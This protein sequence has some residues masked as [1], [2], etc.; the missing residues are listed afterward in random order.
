MFTVAGVTG[1]VGAVVAEQLLAKGQ[2]VRVLVRTEAKGEPWARKGAEVSLGSLDDDASVTRALQGATG[3]FVLLP[4]D[5]RAS[6]L[7]ASQRGTSDAIA[8]AVKASGVRHVVLLSSIGADLETGT[9]PIKGLHY[10]EG[11]LRA[12]GTKLTALRAGSFQENVA[13]SLGPAKEGIYPNFS[14]SADYPMPMIATRDIATVAVTSLLTPPSASEVVDISGPSYSIR[15]VSEKLGAALGKR[16]QVVDVPQANWVQTFLQA[17]LPQ[18]WAEAF[19]EMYAGFAS[20][21]IVP[22]GDRHV[23]GET[24]IDTVIA[25]LVRGA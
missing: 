17:G 23:K 15:Q 14:P 12:T 4:P 5:F 1:H 10:L 18:T 11:A 16:L 3:F 22:K 9:G 2:A 6:D 25:S 8:R 19:A 21:R 20:G 7:F 13:N 24:P